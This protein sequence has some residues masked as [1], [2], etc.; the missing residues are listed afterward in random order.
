M[1]CIRARMEEPLPLSSVGVGARVPVGEGG[2]GVTLAWHV[3]RWFHEYMSLRIYK[4]SFSGICS[5]RVIFFLI[6]HFYSTILL[7]LLLS[8]HPPGGTVI[9]Q[10]EKPVAVH[11]AGAVSQTTV[12]DLLRVYRPHA[13]CWISSRAQISKTSTWSFLE[14]EKAGPKK[15]RTGTRR[16]ARTRFTTII[17]HHFK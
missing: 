7:A 11:V 5:L 16:G 10:Q 8:I 14:W 4:W 15:R 2:G 13:G 9:W 6:L 1:A 17:V 3:E 12:P